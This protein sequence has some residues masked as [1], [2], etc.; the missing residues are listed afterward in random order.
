LCLNIPGFGETNG[1]RAV[2]GGNLKVSDM[3]SLFLHKIVDS[4]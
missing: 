1:V 2:R 3:L 4:A